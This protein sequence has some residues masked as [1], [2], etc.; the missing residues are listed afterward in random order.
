MPYVYFFF[1]G[2][3]LILLILI[4]E[5]E[6]DETEEILELLTHFL[7][8]NIASPALPEPCHVSQRDRV[9]FR[10]QHSFSPRESSSTPVPMGRR[11]VTDPSPQSWGRWAARPVTHALHPTTGARHTAPGAL[12]VPVG[13]APALVSCP[14]PGIWAR[15]ALGSLFGSFLPEK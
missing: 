5:K 3:D 1:S 12:S 7:T 6:S 9:T 4:E 11:R 2:D 14:P 15:R 8:K 13:A 10:R